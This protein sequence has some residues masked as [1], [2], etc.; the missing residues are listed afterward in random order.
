MKGGC[1]SALFQEI[2]GEASERKKNI[3]KENTENE[4]IK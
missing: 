3:D 4:R 1:I 2:T